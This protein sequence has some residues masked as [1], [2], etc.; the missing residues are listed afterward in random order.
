MEFISL[1]VDLVKAGLSHL[2]DSG[3]LAENVW[4]SRKL[5]DAKLL[6]D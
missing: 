1:Q 3:Y 5:S 6:K 2:A 4:S